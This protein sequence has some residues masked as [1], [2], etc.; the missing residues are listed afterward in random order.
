M[1]YPSNSEG[2]FEATSA[3][4]RQFVEQI[5]Q[6]EAEEKDVRDR[7]KEILAEARSRGYDTKVM[8]IVMK[9]RKRDKDDLAEEEHLVETYETALL[10]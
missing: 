2:S 10:V 3:E 5:E 4:L 7:K 1:T 9:R 6:L 8:K